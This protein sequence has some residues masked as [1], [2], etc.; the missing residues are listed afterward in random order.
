MLACLLACLLACCL[1]FS[2]ARSGRSL[3]RSLACLLS[4]LLARSLWSLARSLACCLACSLARSLWSLARLLACCLACSLARSGRSLARLL[5]VWLARSLA[6]IDLLLACLHQPSVCVPISLLV[7]LFSAF[8][9][10]SFPPQARYDLFHDLVSSSQSTRHPLWFSTPE[11][12]LFP[13]SEE[14]VSE[15]RNTRLK[16]NE[17]TGG[18]FHLACLISHQTNGF[19][20]SDSAY[21]LSRPP[22]R[23]FLNQTWLV[24]GGISKVDERLFPSPPQFWAWISHAFSFIIPEPGFKTRHQPDA[25]FGCGIKDQRARANRVSIYPLA[26][27][28]IPYLTIW[29]ILGVFLS[30]L[31]LEVRHQPDVHHRG[32]AGD[33]CALLLPGRRDAL[34]R[35]RAPRRASL[36]GSKTGG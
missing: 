31:E 29:P 20:S 19:N 18:H 14:G 8:F 25:D 6:C 34:G 9:F 5:A 11:R 4:G 21:V 10:F 7:F 22:D 3:A 33:H 17:P 32:W 23:H 2:L 27:W 1:A 12:A 26:I 35:H 28:G 36:R 15:K 24:F 16:S 13:N 30:H